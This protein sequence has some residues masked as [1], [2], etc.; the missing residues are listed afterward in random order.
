MV[1]NKIIF[2]IISLII[3]LLDQ[4]TKLYFQKSINTGAAFGLFKDYTTILIFISL[5]IIG[6]VFHYLQKSDNF[7]LNLGLS[8]ILGGALSNLFD[9]IFFNGVRDFID[10]LLIPSFNIADSFN[11]IGALIIVVYLIKEK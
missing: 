8:F 11:V 1:R 6:I 3:I 2:Y 4:I 9:R 7:T 10:F 5:F